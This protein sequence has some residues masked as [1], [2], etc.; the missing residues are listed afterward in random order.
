MFLVEIS[1]KCPFKQEHCAI[2][3]IKCK[4][5]ELFAEVTPFL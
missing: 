1:R 4:N 5:T 3:K 2:V